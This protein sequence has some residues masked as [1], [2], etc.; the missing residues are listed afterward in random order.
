MALGDTYI[1][2]A[3]LKSYMGIE[4]NT[5]DVQIADAVSSAS[6]EIE[7][8]CHRQFNSASTVSARL[9]RPNGSHLLAVD[10]FSTTVGLI[11]ESDEDGDGV[12]ETTWATTDYEL[13][14]LN[15]VVNGQEGWPFW[16]IRATGI[17]RRFRYNPRAN[18]RVT[19]K[20]GWAAVPTPVI[21]SAYILASDTFQ[22]K[23]SRLGV[24]GS[25]QFGQIVR[26]RD[27]QTAASKLRYYVRQKAF[28]A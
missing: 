15:G 3:L 22:L 28:V 20:W 2:S 17:N 21:Q 12:F 11:V 8:Y 14:P 9:F 13:T 1:T 4:I 25:D 19:A 16:N 5:Y 6:R 24:A 18:V 26:V 23:D 27:N 10:D 7:D